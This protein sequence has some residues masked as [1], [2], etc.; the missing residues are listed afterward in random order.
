MVG[1]T[2]TESGRARFCLVTG[3]ERRAIRFA[4]VIRNLGAHGV[5]VI[6]LRTLVEINAAL[7]DMDE[8]IEPE[9]S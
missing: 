6:D 8:L 4:R 7:A 1:V 3:D 2:T 5:E 9:P